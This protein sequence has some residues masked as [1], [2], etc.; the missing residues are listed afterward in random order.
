MVL[1]V[2]TGKDGSHGVKKRLMF[3]AKQHISN[4]NRYSKSSA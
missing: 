4:A 3:I 1:H 2:G